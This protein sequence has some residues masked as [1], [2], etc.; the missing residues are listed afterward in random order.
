MGER[1]FEALADALAPTDAVADAIGDG[2]GDADTD[3]FALGGRVDTAE[4]EVD[5]SADQCVD[6]GGQV[7][8][9]AEFHG[10]RRGVV[11]DGA[12]GAHRAV[13]VAPHVDAQRA[14]LRSGRGDGLVAGPQ[15]HPGRFEESPP[16]AGQLHRV[17]GAVEQRDTE[18]VLQPGDPLRQRLLGE[19][20]PPGRPAEMQLL[21]RRDGRPR[22]PQVEIHGSHHGRPP[23]FVKADGRLL[24]GADGRPARWPACSP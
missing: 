21:G 17:A 23:P 18:G 10:E 24:A 15:R 7:T 2:I 6:G 5:R 9:G 19:E 22:L 8:A 16:R 20:Q 1:R 13:Q 4:A 12:Q 11:E 14:G 3:G